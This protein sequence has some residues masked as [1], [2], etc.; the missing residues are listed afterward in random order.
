VEV[1]VQLSGPTQHIPFDIVVDTERGKL[2]WIDRFLNLIQRADL[3]GGNVETLLEGPE[4]FV[5]EPP[6]PVGLALDL[7]D[8]RLYWAD[9]VEQVIRRADLNARN[10]EDVVTEGL[11]K[12]RAIVV[13]PPG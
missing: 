2:Y 8:N 6:R 4:G 13:L 11:Q 1:L 5:E 3:D 9:E 10:I 7:Q 12:V